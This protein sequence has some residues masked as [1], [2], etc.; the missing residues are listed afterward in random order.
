MT[1]TV[2]IFSLATQEH[3]LGLLRLWGP[4]QEINCQVN[5]FLPYQPVDPEAIA[6][7]DLV[8]IQRDFSRF[9]DQYAQLI[10]LAA[11]YDKPIV[12][13]IDDLLWELPPEHPDHS[14]GHYASALLPMWLAALHADA[15]TVASP[16]LAEYVRPLNPQVWVLPNYLNE[17]IWSFREPGES[18]STVTRIGYAGG[19]S[20][21]PDLQMIAPIL[22]DILERNVGKVSLHVW[23]F[24]PPPGLAGH[25]F[26][27][28]EALQPGDY[29]HYAAVLGKQT[30]DIALAPLR[31]SHFNRSKSAIKFFEY[32]ALGVPCICS[33]ASPYAAVVENGVTGFLADTPAQWQHALEL[34]VNDGDLRLR[35]AR[36][37]QQHVRDHWL[38][39]THAMKWSEAYQAIVE[40]H[41]VKGDQKARALQYNHLL[42]Q[43][44]EYMKQHDQQHAQIEAQNQRIGALEAELAEIKGSRA[45]KLVQRLWAWRARLSARS[46]HGDTEDH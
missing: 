26:V 28:W 22:L 10:N 16:G 27:T 43:V 3:A 5:W 6:S 31:P 7:S 13:E 2:S 39:S 41:A 46:Q 34:L 24:E 23:G 18:Q 11:T 44:Q 14:S 42:A 29:A 45:W 15:V 21:A 25:P 1:N 9:I 17:R 32:A 19:D 8:V 33:A 38:L 36:Q 40:H 37:A 12:F 4:L 30:F 20:H 35:I